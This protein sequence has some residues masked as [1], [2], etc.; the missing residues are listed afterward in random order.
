[1]DH[2]LENLGPERFQQLCQAM[3][4]KEF[5]G[6]NLFPVGQPDGGRDALQRYAP[7]GNSDSN[8][9]FQVK[10]AK[11]IPE[12]I[13]KWIVEAVKGELHKIQKLKDRGAGVY[14]FISNVPGTSHLDVGSIDRVN[15]ALKSL[16]GMP[17]I[18]WWRD[19]INRRLDSSWDIKL[20]YPETLT[21]QDFF[22]LLIENQADGKQSA[23]IGAINA[24]VKDQYV[25]DEDVKF[26]QVELQNKLL[27]LFVDLP[28]KIEFRG[29]L[30]PFPFP[31]HVNMRLRADAIEGGGYFLSDDAEEEELSGG[32]ASMLLADCGDLLDQLVIEGAPGQGKSTLLQ[33]LC[34]VHRIRILNKNSDLERL[35]EEQ[36]ISPLFIPFKVDLRDLSEW[37]SGNDPFASTS[38]TPFQTSDPRTLETFL[39]HLVTQ[40]SGGIRFDVADLIEILRNNPALIALD[41]LDE[42]ADIKRRGEVVAAVTKATNR[43]R[44]NA[45]HMRVL[46]TSRP[47]A[48]AN[49]PGFDRASF[50]H[51][52]LGSVRRAQINQYAER[53]LNARGILKRDRGE[54][55]KILAEKLDFPHLRDLAK[56]PMQLTIL[57][58]LILTRGSALPD[59][60]TTLYDYYVD[61][62]FSRESSKNFTVRK[63]LELLKDIHRYLAWKLHTATESGRGSAAGRFTADELRGVLKEYLEAEGQ[64]TALIE[65]IFNVT[66]ARVFMIV[67]RIEGTYE[68]EVQP[69]REYFAARYLYDT[70]P[71]SP[72]GGERTGTKPDRFDA[73]ARNFYW[74]NVARFLCGCFSKGELLDL[75]DRIRHLANDGQISHTKHP[76]TL[77]VMLL[78]DWVFSQSPRALGEVVQFLS[79][80]RNLFRVLPIDYW[81]T[82]ST[83][84]VP[85]DSGG[86]E[87]VEHVRKWLAEKETKP[88]IRNRLG[89]FLVA[90]APLE[91]NL[92]WWI[93]IK[94]SIEDSVRWLAIGDTLDLLNVI[95]A[96]K[97]RSLLGTD[98]KSRRSIGMLWG[99]LG[100]SA[101]INDDES[102][103]LAL[104]Y[105]TTGI[106]WMPHDLVGTPVHLAPIILTDIQNFT[107]GHEG[108]L[109]SYVLE[110]YEQRLKTDQPD[111]SNEIAWLEQ[112]CRDFSLRF[113]KRREQ[114]QQ[115]DSQSFW[116][117]VVEDARMTFGESALI[118][119]AS[120]NAVRMRGGRP[121]RPKQCSLFDSVV[122]IGE[123]LRY[124]KYRA[125]D[126][127]WWLDA[128]AAAITQ[129]DKLLW[130]MSLLAFAPVSL[131]D[132]AC[133]SLGRLLEK[134]APSEFEAASSFL[135]LGIQTLSSVTGASS[136]PPI[137]IESPR[138][139][140]LL[141][142]QQPE[143]Y[144]EA[145]LLKHLLFSND[146]T[147]PVQRIRQREAFKAA[148]NGHLEWN[149]ALQIIREAYASGEW[150]SIHVALI[151]RR[152]YVLPSEVAEII[153][154]REEA[155][156]ADLVDLAIK[157][158]TGAVSKRVRAVGT[159]AKRDR[160]FH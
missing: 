145:T 74:L 120:M 114:S 59:R 158:V 42:V 157:Q 73:V 33:Y 153:F 29:A 47:A 154:E 115:F 45:A 116:L 127:S 122:S 112:K 8:I 119:Y 14:Y 103:Q 19:D 17:V 58:S 85:Y 69:L 156:P 148:V 90:N 102:S 15:H 60:R 32:T 43:L 63:Y 98:A 10:F 76:V 128:G 57:L 97:L 142:M 133:E 9:I 93:N 126:V 16:V 49:S 113:L 105:F 132:K 84:R 3:L 64:S 130:L 111:S 88:D 5:P 109:L 31:T 35:P 30:K 51:L 4:A 152:T 99:S 75:A 108:N 125:K 160:W 24:F 117:P 82:A 7:K 36:R 140:L 80:R 11:R 40:R 65:E 61:L 141:A 131:I 13:D 21:G 20:R 83:T 56:N 50:P 48:F 118:F 77:S 12:D 37:L 6:I 94:S 41:G 139:A 100:L 110:H 22:R 71:Y 155:Y 136:V 91:A 66:V 18:G 79:D 89:R 134:W 46:I 135:T 104:D 28:F 138:L 121:G 149:T 81:N 96:D 78:S 55:E 144:G 26:K 67:S 2:P 107:E 101:V 68:F 86:K 34:Q 92:N 143:R 72:P 1:M 129:H 147:F 150:I 106:R 53:W 70:A 95:P 123:R 23:R 38:S 62:F 54:F 44:E 137:D 87:L 39:A 151:H 159:T 25:E 124:A 52:Q 146:Q 27:D